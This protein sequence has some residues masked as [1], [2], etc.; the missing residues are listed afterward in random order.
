M[1]AGLILLALLPLGAAILALLWPLR[2]QAAVDDASGGTLAILKDQLAEL[3]RDAGR[4]LI[5]ETEAKAARLE[6]ERRLLK[7]ATRAEPAA[8]QATGLGRNLVLTALIAVPLASA[9]LYW[10]LGTPSLRD[11]P[12][13]ARDAERGP[14][15][16][17]EIRAMVAGLEA[18]LEAA[19]D[20][21][22]GWLMLGRSR[23]T[24]G[25]AEPAID[26]YRKAMAL[27]PEDGPLAAEAI[28]GLAEALLERAMGVVTPE[29]RQ[30]MFQLAELSPDD[31]RPGFY[32][33]L[34]DAQA[35]DY[36]GALERWRVLLAATPADAPWRERIEPSIRQAA[37]ALGLDPEPI[38]ALGAPPAPADSVEALATELAGLPP[39]ARAARIRAMVRDLAEQLASEGGPPAAWQRL[40]RAYLVIGERALAAQAF[41]TA[42]ETAPEDAGLHKD[43]AT[44]LM[45]APATADGLP[46]VTDAALDHLRN[47][48]TLRPDD[49]E[50]HWYLGIR[51]LADD[52]IAKAHDHWTLVLARLP[53][54]TAE[55]ALVR[56][57]LERLELN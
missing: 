40:G 44:A 31:P 19:P 51:A 53:P 5:G 47:A 57:Q 41:E 12:L 54:D 25:Q 17:E 43:L 18:R 14:A 36:H 30:L 55:H 6:I 7:A 28:T 13:A 49:P 24:L 45:E 10:H 38:L 16:P 2:R 48:L 23:L 21:P 42:L 9:A 50:L 27:V 33:G 15:V 34:A 56:R 20:D 26:A 39:E 4:G 52:E 37:E 35:G 11:L 46:V 29:I 32:L 22:E 1:S 8:F 3:E